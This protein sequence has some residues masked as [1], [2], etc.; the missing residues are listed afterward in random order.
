M[1]N[2]LE[3]SKCLASLAVFRELYDN[4]K[5][6]Y[7]VIS[8]FLKEVISSNNTYQFGLTEITQILNDSYDFKIPEAVVKTSLSRLDF[9]SKNNGIYSVNKPVE[10]IRDK[11]FQEKQ[12]RIYNSNKNVV[13]H[14]FSYIE[15]QKKT[16]LSETEKELIIKSLCSFMLDE[17]TTQEYSEYIGAFIVKCESE[18]GLLA[19]LDTIKEGVVLYT[20]LKYNS[21]LNDLGTWNTQIT[22]FIETEILF[23]FA[24]Y[25]GELFKILF[26]DFFSF[27]KEINSQSINRD[28]KK[29][30]HLKYFSEVKNEIERFFKKAEFIINGNDTLNPSKTAMSSIVNGC[31]TPSDIIE[32]KALFYDLLKTN[33]ITE[34]TYAEYYSAKNHAFN[35][36]DQSIIDALQSSGITDN[37]IKE[38]FKFLNYVN[39]HRQGVSDRNFENIGYIL[40]S[41]NAVTIQLAWHDLIKPNGNVPLATTLSFLTNK[42][43]FRLGKGFGKNNYPKTFDIIT[44]AQLVL[45][46]QVNDSISDKYNSLQ[47]KLE[48]GEFN[49]KQALATILELRRQA[50]KPEDIKGDDLTDILDTI[51]E[52]S[53]EKYVKE[54][55]LFK[56]QAAQEKKENENLKDEISEIKQENKQQKD[57]LEKQNSIIREYSIRLLNIEND[58]NREAFSKQREKYQFDRKAYVNKAL[59]SIYKKSLYSVLY[60]MIFISLAIILQVGQIYFKDNKSNSIITAII[61]LVLFLIPFLR[62]FIKHDKILYS[63]NYIFS[64]RKRIILNKE[65]IRK[66]IANY[67]KIAKSPI[68]KIKKEIE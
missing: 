34:D 10:Q 28:S 1:E 21:N 17:S 15:E 22:I 48:K 54:Q 64:Q 30:I 43:W 42:F 26:N 66:S 14:L 57:I 67:S 6:V 49:E 11:K 47:K 61:G 36:E 33:G 4:Q 50:K 60:Y 44:K 65:I 35:I 46:T 63:I 16:V 52:S 40:L 37:D 53:I 41:G 7:G 27:V 2:T 5:D 3:N 8:E 32:K 58:K 25:N 45:S 56:I 18:E 9:L 20:G 24:G 62:S 68:L 38:N 19:Q 55:E 29:K 51:S 31:N 23:H 12:D 13:S 59:K 39:I